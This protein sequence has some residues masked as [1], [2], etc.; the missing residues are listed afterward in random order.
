MTPAVEAG[1]EG[2]DFFCRREGKSPPGEQQDSVQASP[3]QDL[4]VL[5]LTAKIARDDSLGLVARPARL[6]IEFHDATEFLE[7]TRLWLL[8]E[9]VGVELDAHGAG[10]YR[11]DGISFRDPAHEIKRSGQLA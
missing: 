11:V 3:L 10:K 1:V 8:D 7:A 6:A 2:A 9:E 4:D 5:Q